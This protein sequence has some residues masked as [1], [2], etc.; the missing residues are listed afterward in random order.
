MDANVRGRLRGRHLIEWI[1]VVF[2][3]A[4]VTGVAFGYG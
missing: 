1:M 3:F 2:S 4:M